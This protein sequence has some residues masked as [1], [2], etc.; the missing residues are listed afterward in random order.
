MFPVFPFLLLLIT[1]PALLSAQQAGAV[2]V[3]VVPVSNESESSQLDPVATTVT[4]TILLTLR[5]LGQYEASRYDG[6]IDYPPSV[7]DLSLLARSGPAESVL[8]GA[9]DRNGSGAIGLELRV[10]DRA[11]NEVVLSEEATSDSLLDLFGVADEL[12]A[13]VV[14]GFSGRRIAFGSLR[15][16]PGGAADRPYSVYL[17]GNLLGRSIRTAESVLT[18]TH[19]LRIVAD[20][21]MGSEVVYADEIVLEEGLTTAVSF[22]IPDYTAEQLEAAAA[23]AYMEG[24]LETLLAERYELEESWETL[25]S[26]EGL[27]SGE[28]GEAP[29]ARAVAFSLTV[30]NRLE[31]YPDPERMENAAVLAPLYHAGELGRWGRRLLSE[32][33][34]EEGVDAYREVAAIGASAP[35]GKLPSLEQLNA[36]YPDTTY[37]AERWTEAE[38][39]AERGFASGLGVGL[40]ATTIFLAF[41]YG[42]PSEE[43]SSGLYNGA[44]NIPL[45]AAAG[46]TALWLGWDHD[47]WG[48]RRNLKRYGRR[49]EL[50]DGEFLDSAT[51]GKIDIG[52]GL[53]FEYAQNIR[54][55][56]EPVDPTIGDENPEYTFRR[57]APDL[58]LAFYYQAMRRHSLGFHLRVPTRPSYLWTTEANQ[59]AGNDPSLAVSTYFDGRLSWDHTRT[60]KWFT[61]LGLGYTLFGSEGRFDEGEISQEVQSYYDTIAYEGELLHAPSLTIGLGRFYGRRRSSPFE[62]LFYYRLHAIYP[63]TSYLGEPSF[64]HALGVS[65]GKRFRIGNITSPG[66]LGA[67]EADAREGWTSEGGVSAAGREGASGPA[68]DHGDEASPPTSSDWEGLFREAEAEAEARYGPRRLAFYAD[69]AGILTFGPRFGVAY[70][71]RNAWTLGGYLRWTLYALPYLGLE[72]MPERVSP[73]ITLRRYP[74]GTPRASGWFYGG[75]LEYRNNN[76]FHEETF[77][78]DGATTERVETVSEGHIVALLAEGGYRF[79]RGGGR[80]IDLGAFLGVGLGRYEYADI[81]D[82]TSDGSPTLT[83]SSVSNFFS[84]WAGVTASFG[85]PW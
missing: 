75:S 28:A 33:E 43:G 19:R 5:L 77:R 79:V 3:L 1:H 10:Y 55:L 51:P 50:L 80:F 66:F 78:I 84:P 81:G 62:A 9:V 11:G 69:L 35:V 52:V 56:S 42:H 41:D 48:D 4:D 60:G 39:H 85:A 12:T 47:R 21:E 34:L 73:G 44:Q 72:P 6:F 18:G 7:D 57:T 29:D 59:I 68:P 46:A 27:D 67:S 32:E 45:L 31:S 65:F 70:D 23:A 14:S 49:G 53:G 64:H 30:L 61:R 82:D 13:R 38:L 22:T 2:R 16:S 54:K 25:Q 24:D 15:L 76:Y 63:P 37:V 36:L 26:G 40:A 58:R 20:T 74:S 83:H 17:D 71:L 8:Y